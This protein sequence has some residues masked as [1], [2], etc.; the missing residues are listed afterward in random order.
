MEDN[1][2]LYFH[3]KIYAGQIW[4]NQINVQLAD[5]CLRI[6]YNNLLNVLFAL[7]SQTFNIP[8]EAQNMAMI[9]SLLNINMLSYQDTNCQYEKTDKQASS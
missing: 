9:R 5:S 2:V 8:E 4:L 7:I 3:H 6:K 1:S